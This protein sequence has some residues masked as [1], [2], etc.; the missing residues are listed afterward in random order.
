M[1]AAG[2][3]TPITFYTTEKPVQD[4]ASYSDAVKELSRGKSNVWVKR[5]PRPMNALRLWETSHNGQ[6]D[7][8]GELD[9]K[10]PEAPQVAESAASKTPVEN[11]KELTSMAQWRQRFDMLFPPRR[12]GSESRAGGENLKD[13]ARKSETPKTRDYR[14]D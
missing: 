12:A 8:A 1:R 6:K 11:N 3:E 2:P 10:G 5:G 13:D 4:A 7:S 14:S 9:V